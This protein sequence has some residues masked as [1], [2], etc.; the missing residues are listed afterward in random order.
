MT[1]GLLLCDHVDPDLVDAHSTYTDMFRQLLPGLTFNVYPVCDG[2]FPPDPGACDA[3]MVNGSRHSV[4]DPEDWITDL[5]DF[6]RMVHLKRIPYIGICFGHQ[7]LAEALG[8]EVK[9]AET[10]WCV[11]VHRFEITRIMDWMR[12]SAA[13]I[14]LLMM[15]QDQ[16][17]MLPPKA[18]ILGSTKECPIGM[19][20]VDDH[21]LGIQAHPEFS[22]EYET[23][24]LK[25]RSLRIGEEKTNVALQSLG[26]QLDDHRISGWILNFLKALL[27][28]ESAK[29][30]I[31]E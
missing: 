3:Y 28:S 11:G 17:H 4:Y 1:V 15:C 30:S 22:I 8:G 31:L 6:V 24:L 26:A 19:F 9:K 29:M 10:G 2:I 25:K 14:Q 21:M 27:K 18:T 16:V 13:S 23:T 7:L 12:P 5:M 20:L